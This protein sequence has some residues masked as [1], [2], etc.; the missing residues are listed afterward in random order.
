MTGELPLPATDQAAFLHEV[1]GGPAT[2]Q[3]SPCLFPATRLCRADSVW[4]LASPFPA[5]QAAL[6]P[7]TSTFI[8]RSR[9]ATGGGPWDPKGSSEQQRPAHVRPGLPTRS[10]LVHRA[11]IMVTSCHAHM[12]PPQ[13]SK[14]GEAQCCPP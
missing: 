2:V 10:A 3:V 11:F 14:S 9:G 13:L 7:S 1:P 12:F 4:V 5:P 8:G 6:S